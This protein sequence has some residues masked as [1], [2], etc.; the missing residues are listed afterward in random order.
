MILDHTHILHISPM[1]YAHTT[2]TSDTYVMLILYTY[3]VHMLYTCLLYTCHI[4]YIAYTHMLLAGCC[5]E[6]DREFAC[7][8][9]MCM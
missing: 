9:F 7:I 1:L 5:M 3:I 6:V 8:L 2:P 4:I